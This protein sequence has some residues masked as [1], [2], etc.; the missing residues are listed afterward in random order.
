MTKVGLL[1]CFAPY[2]SIYHIYQL[3]INANVAP[4]GLATLKITWIVASL[5]IIMVY[6][7]CIVYATDVH[8]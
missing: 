5:P 3:H 4:V 1:I 7:D 6:V 8:H 2:N